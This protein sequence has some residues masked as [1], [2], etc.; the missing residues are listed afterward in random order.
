MVIEDQD[1]TQESFSLDAIDIDDF[2]TDI[3]VT[4]SEL[5]D[6]LE[7]DLAEEIDLAIAIA[8]ILVQLTFQQFHLSLVAHIIIK[9]L[10][11]LNLSMF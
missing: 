8:E 1:P 2:Q 3:N 11:S 10:M 7:A 6:N 4:L 9:H 5:T